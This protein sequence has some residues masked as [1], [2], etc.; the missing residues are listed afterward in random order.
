MDAHNGL[1]DDC[2][3]VKG[4]TV[5]LLISEIFGGVN[6]TSLRF[7]TRLAHLMRGD[8]DEPHFDRAGKVVPFFVYHARALS[9]AAAVGHGRVLQKHA[10]GVRARAVRLSAQSALAAGVAVG[11]SPG[12]AV[13]AGGV[14]CALSL[15]APPLVSVY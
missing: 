10:A 11:P 2:V 7:L 12:G 5:L 9:R 13:R 8:S 3:N 14:G 4:N 1:Y 15:S 6:G